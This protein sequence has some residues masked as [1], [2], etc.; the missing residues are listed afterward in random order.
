MPGAAAAAKPTPA[1]VAV[2][3]AARAPEARPEFYTVRRGDTLYG[4][5][6]DHGLEYREIA[7]WNNLSDPN[8]IRA[9]QVLS[10]RAPAQ[11]APAAGAAQVRPVTGVEAPESRPLAASAPSPQGAAES[12]PPAEPGTAPLAAET[13]TPA[14][15]A[16]APKTE[17]RAYKLPYSEENIA[18]MSRGEAARTEA[19]LEPRP[20][21]KPE[22]RSPAARKEPEGDEEDKV[23]WGWPTSGRVLA[24][25]S[26]PANKGVDVS[27][28]IGDP[29][30]A[31]AS[32]RVVYSGAGLRGYGKLV[33]IKHNKTFLS[34][35]AHNHQILV[36]EGQQVIKGQ[37]IAEVGDS[38]ADGPR[39][40]FEIRR[41][42]KPV[43]PL[44]YLPERQS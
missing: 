16:L 35:Y 10:L 12:K 18:L 13:K 41:L 23:D 17:P 1:P 5:A 15:G 25:F 27:G 19:R 31:S 33:I 40:H 20:E 4:I 3:P 30:F 2:P 9:G 43:D 26:E 22:P 6:L 24:G 44:K 42:G 7:E 34:A 21:I 29:V 38:D 37:K 8:Q 28:K 14:G 36:K 32:G 11:S 39:L